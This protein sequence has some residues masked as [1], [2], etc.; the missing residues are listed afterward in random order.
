MATVPSDKKTNYEKLFASCIIKE[1]KYPEIDKITAKMVSNK[2]RYESVGD[3]LNIPWYVIAIIH[4]MEASLRFDTH[5]HN[6]DSLKERTVQVPA[7]RPK[8][9]NPPFT[10][11]ESAKD[12]VV[13]DKLNT[14]TDWSIA[15]IL[16][17]LELYNGLGYYRQGINSPYLWSYSNHYI[18]GKYVQDG[19]Y[20]PNAISKQC[21]AAVLLRRMSEQKLIALSNG[22][23][24]EQI[25]ALGNKT[26]YYSG[27]VTNEAKELQTLLN[28]AGSIL[29]V[30]GKAGERTST[31]YFKYSGTYLKGDPR[32]V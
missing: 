29:R 10:W 3:R 27:T 28:R 15:G 16:Y 32:G 2:A 22:N 8:L 9:G 7:G 23:L 30:D 11:E 14:W 19:R 5:L 24:V 26:K 6:G 21:G 18:K 25:L 31:E 1:A 13:Y 20:D 4:N 17:K 12:A